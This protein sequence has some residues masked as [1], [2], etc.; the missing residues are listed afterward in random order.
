MPDGAPP[1]VARAADD[2]PLPGHDYANSRATTTSR[3]NT[4][5]VATLQVAWRA[6]PQG[7]GQL[8]TSPLV[9][10]DT[11]YFEDGNGSVFALDRATGDVRW[12]SKSTGFNIG[13]FGVAVGHGRVYAVH[14]SNGVTALDAR[15]GDEIWT[16]TLSPNTTTGVDIQ[17]QVFDG[18]VLV[19]TVPVSIGG[20]YVGGDHGVVSALD[21]RTGNVIWEFDTVDSADLWGNPSVNSGGGAWYPPAVDAARGVAYVG[22]ANP[23]PFPGTAEYPNGSSRPGKN[24]YTDSLVALDL[25]TGALRWY[26]QV[27]PHDI[28]DRDQVHAMTAQLPDGTD[29]VVSAG[30]S[31]V[32]LGIDPETG[33]TVWRTPVGRHH[34][35]DLE[36]LTGPTVVA[37]GT[38]GGVLTPPATAAGIVYLPVVNAPVTLK[39]DETAYFGADVAKGRGEI[40]ALDAET[41]AVRWARKVPGNPLGGTTVVNDL[42]FT[43]LVDGTVL[44][45]D[46]DNGR[47]VW[48]YEA[49]GGINGWMSVAGDMIVIPVGNASPPAML[50]LSLPT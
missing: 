9:L 50:A 1:E 44:A 22:I 10:G 21:A 16:H 48:T 6:Q 37:P 30:K 14:G 3:I 45:L 27:T 28:F 33:K 8:T 2:W 32:V 38:Y 19:S 31:G 4:G 26:Q 23:A 18:K 34:N 41:G 36:A 12:K 29:V 35:D 15:T 25:E 40:V 24:L 42:V 47:V 20:I 17:P 46:R 49:G 5:N 11:A 13:P 43:A 7:L 39:P